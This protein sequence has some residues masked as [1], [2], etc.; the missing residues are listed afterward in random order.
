[1]KMVAGIFSCM[2]PRRLSLALGLALAFFGLSLPV[3]AED[4]PFDLESSSWMSFDRY[5]EKPSSWMAP[6]D[7][8][9]MALQPVTAPAPV[10]PADMS[11][12]TA[13][14]REIMPPV[15][16]ALNKGFDVQVNS[17]EDNNKTLQSLLDDQQKRPD[18]E[19]DSKN[20]KAPADAMRS[21]GGRTSFGVRFSYLPNLQMP[22]AAPSAAPVKKAV[23]AQ[24][25]P[26]APVVAPKP[27]VDPA[28]CAALEAYKKRQLEAIESDRQTLTALKNAISQLGLQKQLDFMTSNSGVLNSQAAGAP[29]AAEPAMPARKN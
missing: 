2:R 6:D 12:I 24:A 17:T 18:Q 13:P 3:L 25:K 19:L 26:A 5:K 21:D 4:A 10:M 27:V 8:T 20:W 22:K 9:Q 7:R 14:T 15:M 29:D 28:V 23:V 1:M 16:P 11:K